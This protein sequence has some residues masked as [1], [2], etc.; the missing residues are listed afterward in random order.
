[1]VACDTRRVDR[2]NCDGLLLLHVYPLRNV[3]RLCFVTFQITSDIAREIRR[4]NSVVVQTGCCVIL[5]PEDRDRRNIRVPK[6]Y[7]V[8]RTDVQYVEGWSSPNVTT[9]LIQYPCPSKYS[10]HS[11]RIQ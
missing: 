4:E 10:G 8:A 11:S 5:L 1:M 9:V 3:L 2:E 6:E 7:E